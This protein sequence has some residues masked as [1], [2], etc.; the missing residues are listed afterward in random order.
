MLRK[1]ARQEARAELSEAFEEIKAT[2]DAIIE[3]AKALP[4]TAR[5]KIAK[6]RASLSRPIITLSRKARTWFGSETE[7]KPPE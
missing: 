7:Q 3:I 1:K 5:H 2:D 6:L 4:F